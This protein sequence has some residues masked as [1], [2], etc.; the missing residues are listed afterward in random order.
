VV[1]VAIL[2]ISLMPAV[3]SAGGSGVTFRLRMG[4]FCIDGST[5][6]GSP[7]R[8]LWK[9]ANGSIKWDET[10]PSVNEGD[11]QVCTFGPRLAPGDLLK[12]TVGNYIRSFTVPNLTMAI[13]RVNNVVTGTGRP[14]TALHLDQ[15]YVADVAVDQDGNWSYEPGND[16][17]GNNVFW[18]HWDSARG[19]RIEM[20][21][22]APQLVLMLGK[23]KFQIA[24]TPYS[25][26]TITLT[27]ETANGQ[28]VAA[29][30]LDFGGLGGAREDFI[31][32]DGRRM[33]VQP[34]DHVSAPAIAADAD[35]IVPN[36][37]ARGRSLSNIVTGRCFD[38]G[39]SAGL[40]MLFVLDGNNSKGGVW[41]SVN[42]D[43]SFSV[44]FDDP[45]SSPN[46]SHYTQ[47][48]DVASGDMLHVWCEQTTGDF[49]RAKIAVN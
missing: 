27:R 28:R 41:G 42:A 7:F 48:A 44:D 35:W 14:G 22:Y 49:V 43:G 36:I 13:D 19:D 31:D 21:Q 15:P 10:S 20:V 29:M 9:G 8:V 6:A 33:R 47:A 37:E 4:D 3:V 38:A 17:T 26:A 40:Y 11:W 2:W 25:E 45:G 18:A 32:Q 30:D 12:V 23:P 46:V 16:F 1:L 39:T 24:G 34:G 5:Q